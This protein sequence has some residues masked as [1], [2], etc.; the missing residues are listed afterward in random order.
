MKK[1]GIIGCGNM[2]EAILAG[3]RSKFSII[4]SETSRTRQ[5]YLKKVYRLTTKSIA[6]LLKVC[7]V[8]V[9]AVKPQGI[10]DALQELKGAA[11]SKKLFISIAAGITTN[12]LEK[13]IGA[14]ARV[15]R[16][17]PN[18][19]AKIQKGATAVCRGKYSSS[20]DIRVAVSIFD[21]IGKTIV[22]KENLMDS[23][24]AVSGSGPGYIYLF[25]EEMIKAAKA[26]GFNEKIAS[27]LVLQSF[28]GS[29]ELLKK[30]KDNAQILRKRVT[31]KGG[32]TQAAID[33]FSKNKI[34]VIFKQALRAA[35]KRSK[36]L[37]RR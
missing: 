26:L 25:I 16:A 12:Y 37:S 5:K 28:D 21:T 33:V 10:D 24:T 31:S 22:V 7:D 3:A 34:D 15:V 14:K 4:V 27:D 2:G 11:L 13:K 23:V 1:I 32:T 19:P 36:A 20:Q 30:S 9:L 35:Q 6:D 8:V 17:M 18:L 29:I